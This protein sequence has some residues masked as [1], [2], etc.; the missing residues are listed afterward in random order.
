LNYVGGDEQTA[1]MH[2]VFERHLDVVKCLLDGGA[3]VHQK[4][5]W[6]KTVKDMAEHSSQEIK[7]LLRR[8]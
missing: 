4:N 2:A 1:L 8:A 5:Y 7:D 3:G 6:G